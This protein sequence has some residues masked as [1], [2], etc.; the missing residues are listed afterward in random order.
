MINALITD[1]K[2]LTYGQAVLIPVLNAFESIEKAKIH[3][4]YLQMYIRQIKIMR[5]NKCIFTDLYLE[6]ILYFYMTAVQNLSS[7]GCYPTD[8]YLLE[9]NEFHLLTFK[10]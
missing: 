5:N 6:K 8:E 10:K 4:D 2:S 3:N 9:L 7:L 1:D